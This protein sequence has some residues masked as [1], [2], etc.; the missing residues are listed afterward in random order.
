MDEL[1]GRTIKDSAVAST[2]FSTSNEFVLRDDV[3]LPPPSKTLLLLLALGKDDKLL[4][5]FLRAGALIG[6]LSPYLD[7]KLL[8]LLFLLFFL[9]LPP[10][11]LLLL[12]S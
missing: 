3:I 12:L 8:L 11:L 2:I 1:V 5:D 10:P 6:R 9:L 4:V 7:D